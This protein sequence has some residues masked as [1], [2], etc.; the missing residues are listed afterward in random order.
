MS[1]SKTLITHAEREFFTNFEYDMSTSLPLP[2]EKLFGKESFR[3]SICEIEMAILHGNDIT[4][5]AINLY[6]ATGKALSCNGVVVCMQGNQGSALAEKAT[7]IQARKENYA[8][9]TIR[10]SSLIGNAKLHGIGF[11]GPNKASDVSSN[12]EESV[13]DGRRKRARSTVSVST[14]SEDR[15][16]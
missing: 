3:K 6:T 10:S 5:P 9:L 1:G 14:T 16:R 4:C 7:V 11:F 13:S 2:L 15:S 8:V 12:D